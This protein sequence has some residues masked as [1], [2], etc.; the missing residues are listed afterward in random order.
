MKPDT[1]NSSIKKIRLAH[2]YGRKIVKLLDKGDGKQYRKVG[3]RDAIK[4]LSDDN[5]A[6]SE[7]TARHYAAFASRFSQKDLSNLIA[8]S[9]KHGYCPGFDVVA[10]LLAVRD[11]SVRA[12]LTSQV[13]INGWGKI[14]LG[15][16]IRDVEATAAFAE[17]DTGT[18]LA[19][20]NRGRNPRAVADIESLLG[21]LQDDA[22]KWQRI[23]AIL[24]KGK[25]AKKDGLVGK[26]LNAKK[27]NELVTAIPDVL[28]KDI[29]KLTGV[30]QC[31]FDYE[32]PEE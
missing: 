16:E 31:F 29:K 18:H 26:T 6:I 12:S 28:M 7:A 30:L 24:L 15:Q 27:V 1:L 25:K 22:I 21:A 3:Y 8:D 2:K 9:R 10:R 13:Q 20:R 19:E 14:R 5:V 4:I 23:H 32:I 11:E 17:K